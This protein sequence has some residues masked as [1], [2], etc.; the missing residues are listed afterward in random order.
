[1]KIRLAIGIAL[2]LVSFKFIPFGFCNDSEAVGIAPPSLSRSDVDAAL[3]IALGDGCSGYEH[4]IL[5]ELI[6]VYT[7]PRDDS[8]VEYIVKA[9]R[10]SRP[11]MEL[12]MNPRRLPDDDVYTPADPEV[13]IQ[14]EL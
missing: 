10:F 14:L 7:P 5:I 3:R 11:Q 13:Y 4:R 1:M 9:H 8:R 12:S 6:I 2:Y